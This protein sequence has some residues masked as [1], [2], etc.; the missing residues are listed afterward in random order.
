[1]ASS[2]KLTHADEWFFRLNKTD[3]LTSERFVI[4][5]EIYVCRQ[6]KACYKSSS[7][8]E[9]S[10]H[11]CVAL[12][13]GANNWI[14][15]SEFK[16]S[17]FTY[18]FG[19]KR[20]APEPTYVPTSRP[21]YTP[22]YSNHTAVK[23]FSILI[24]ILVL[25]IGQII[26]YVIYS[27][28]HTVLLISLIFGDIPLPF[29][30]I[31][32]ICCALCTTL[33]CVNSW[34]LA[35][36]DRI[37]GSWS[38]N[39]VSDVL[40]LAIPFFIGSIGIIA[41]PIISIVLSYTI[42]SDYEEGFTKVFSI[43]FPILIYI[44]GQVVQYYLYV[45]S[46]TSILLLGLL[47]QVPL[48]VLIVS[49]IAGSIAIGLACYNAWQKADDN[50]IGNAW[51][52]FI[53]PSVCL[54][55][56]P[57][58]FGIPCVL[59][60][61]I[62]TYQIS[63]YSEEFIP[64]SPTVVSFIVGQIILYW[65][66]IQNGDIFVLSRLV[67]MSGAADFNMVTFLVITT[68]FTCAATIIAS[69]LGWY[70]V[71][72]DKLGHAYFLLV[73][74]NL[75]ILIV[76]TISAILLLVITIVLLCA[77]R[78]NKIRTLIIV[79][80]SITLVAS[81]IMGIVSATA[82]VRVYTIAL[83]ARGGSGGT[84][85]IIVEYNE[86]MPE[87]EAPVREGYEFVGYFD[88]IE[89][90]NQYYSSDMQS[91]RD[92][93]Q[94]SNITL[95][96]HWR[97]NTY[98]ITF[99][100]Q[101]G[102]GGTSSVTVTYD[103]PMPTASAPTRA[104]YTF[105]GY[106]DSDGYTQYYNSSMQSVR[107]WDQTSNITLYAHW[108]AN[109]YTITFDKQGGTGGTSSVTVTYDSPMPTASAPTRAGYT[110]SGYYDSDGYTQY[111]NSS[112]QSVRNWDQPSNATLY[113]HWNSSL[114]LHASRSSISDLNDS[115]RITLSVTGGSGN[116]TYRVSNS[117]SG[118]NYSI[119]GNIL[120][121]SKRDNNASG[122]IRITVTDNSYGT[123][124][125][126]SITYT[127][128]SCVAAGT[129]VAMADGTFKKIED[130]QIGD[131]V[132]S[133][134][135]IIGQIEA[136]P[137]SLYWNHGEA[138]YKILN[139]E[140]SNGATVRVINT[141]GFFN[142]TLNKFIYINEENYRDYIGHEFVSIDALDGVKNVLLTK[143]SVTEEFIGCYSLRTACNDNAILSNL[144][145]LTWE[146]YPGMLT[147]FAMGSDLKYDEAKMQ[148]DIETYGLY[149]YEEWK[150]YVTY[151]EFVALNGKYFKILVG[152]GILTIEDIYTL[153][154]GLRA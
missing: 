124:A 56:L 17:F 151:E 59:V 102:T 61:G 142:Y 141:H 26:Q 82:G 105:S 119:S 37:A 62:I 14:S 7:W 47:D 109:T 3:T 111:Y 86:P 146:D 4:G 30:V 2:H 52:L 108:R 25:I 6:C 113:A 135:F 38:L 133:W 87:A 5:D 41:F 144:L 67:E 114:S 127:T 99:D 101:G 29:M 68:I 8:A 121:V 65:G 83:D 94:T 106:Y 77:K 115:T 12:G 57:C 150:E 136:T 79:F 51:A 16:Q 42:Y 55:A 70:F 118:I 89:S 107:N 36:D 9:L 63:E 28:N 64:V 76:P 84:T 100:K 34:L 130:V 91:V 131:M 110:F 72:D 24:P 145:S 46:S 143:V 74:F 126:C 139:L 60:L 23:I 81:S 95:Y 20:V 96:A 138:I 120:T 85:E 54:S 10:E 148:S 58:I 15:D 39:L 75:L 149:T 152:K 147:Y 21:T 104:G 40:F 97:A 18:K 78:S 69:Y 122:T 134:N 93:D 45:T 19:V 90:G 98:T 132:L 22:T 32:T 48:W 154:E 27:H 71:D 33:I 49:T 112:M 11:K 153:I 129:L 53:I 128:S 13:C 92:W 43:V 123:T 66:Y 80:L 31:S 140:F 50:E 1:M 125:S 35:D 116:Y 88:E 137:V 117:P 73:P 44:A 103:S